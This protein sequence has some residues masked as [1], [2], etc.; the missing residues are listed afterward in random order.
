MIQAVIFDMDGLLL[1]TEPKWQETEGL[2]AK[3]WGIDISPENQKKTLGLKSIDLFRYW[4]QLKPWANPDFEKAE[5]EIHDIM[6]GF[7]KHE[8]QLMKGAL[9]ILDFFKQRKL[10]MALASSSPMMLINAFIYRYNI[11]N[12]FEV[13][14]SAEFED[15][16]KP[17]PGVYITT[18]KKL[19][20]NAPFCL[21]IEDSFNGLL[22]AKA[23]GMKTL[24]VPETKYFSEERLIIADMKLR[25]LAEFGDAELGIL[26]SI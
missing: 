24:V 4:H 2:F 1:D 23:A 14:H 26:N 6:D 15:Y 11:Q 5:S 25:S 17:H 13:I 9:E 21:A 20:V 10:K 7:Y 3:K 16:G 18:A 12:Y 8:A 22:A 19:K